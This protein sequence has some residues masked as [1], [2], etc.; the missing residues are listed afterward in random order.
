MDDLKI[1]I[2]QA[3]CLSNA[4]EEY[5][6]VCQIWYDSNKVLRGL[7]NVK[8]EE[9]RPEIKERLIRSSKLPRTSLISAA[10]MRK[11]LARKERDGKE[12]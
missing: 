11:R 10:E 2:G 7:E 12:V 6:G 3:R 4:I 5:F 1:L 8:E 9:L